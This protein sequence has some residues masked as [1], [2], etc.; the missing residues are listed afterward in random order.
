MN[1]DT[2]EKILYSCII[3]IICG[4]VILT[5]ALILFQPTISVEKTQVLNTTTG[6][7]YE[8]YEEVLNY[9]Y[10]QYVMMTIGAIIIFVSLGTVIITVGINVRRG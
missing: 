4:A 5:S 9:P 3:G 7:Y 2:V 1:F 8:G 6:K 10:E